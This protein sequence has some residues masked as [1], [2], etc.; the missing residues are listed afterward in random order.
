[1]GSKFTLVGAATLLWWLALSS[2]AWADS[3]IDWHTYVGS[4]SSDYGRSVATDDHGHFY[5][6]GKSDTDWGTPTSP[7]SGVHAL[8][9]AK[10]QPNG[11]LLWLT[12]LPTANATV[13]NALIATDGDGNV[14][15]TGISKVTWGSP[16]HPHNGRG[17]DVF[18]AKLDR[19]GVVQWHTFLGSCAIDHTDLNR[20]TTVNS[21]GKI[22]RSG[23]NGRRFNGSPIDPHPNG[24]DIYI[25]RLDKKGILLWN[26][27]LSASRSAQLPR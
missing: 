4:S 11:A 25:A 21:D 2:G 18:L 7:L 20:S 10:F 13:Y 24:V 9:V 1:M 27:I 26:T 5:V 17:A 14:Y 6:I 3:L 15:V 23:T 16:V 12:A 22:S 19:A 8:V